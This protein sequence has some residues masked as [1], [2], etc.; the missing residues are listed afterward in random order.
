[1]N[2]A[3][4]SGLCQ[5]EVLECVR[6][7]LCV[8]MCKHLCTSAMCPSWNLEILF[9]IYEISLFPLSYYVI[10]LILKES[11]S[12]LQ[13]QS[14]ILGGYCSVK[15]GLSVS[16]PPPGWRGAEQRLP[17]LYCPLLEGPSWFPH[18]DTCPSHSHWGEPRPLGPG[19]FGNISNYKALCYF[20]LHLC[21]YLIFKKT[22]LCDFV[23]GSQGGNDHCRSNKVYICFKRKSQEKPVR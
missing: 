10:V 17:A 16:V 12:L 1:M 13:T 20:M 2:S 3:L 8:F 14:L 15:R 11:P 5:K 7:C 19:T 4:T 23:Q 6:V 9:T 18:T 22:T 21:R